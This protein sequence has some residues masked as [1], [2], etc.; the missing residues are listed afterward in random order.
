MVSVDLYKFE[1]ELIIFIK[2]H[3][4]LGDYEQAVDIDPSDQVSKARVAMV[5][6]SMAVRKYDE[7]AYEE[8]TKLFSEAIA[9]NPGVCSYYISRARTFYMMDVCGFVFFLKNNRKELDIFRIVFR[10]NNQPN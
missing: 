3:F 4:A 7:K 10:I 8:S 9:S 1:C 5:Y 6:F 2:I